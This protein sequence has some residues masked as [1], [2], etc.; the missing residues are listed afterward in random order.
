[1]AG[2]KYII[3]SLFTNSTWKIELGVDAKWKNVWEL[4]ENDGLLNGIAIFTNLAIKIN[5]T[6]LSGQN[7]TDP[8]KI[9]LNQFNIPLGRSFLRR[10]QTSNHNSYRWFYSP[11]GTMQGENFSLE[12][13]IYKGEQANC[14]LQLKPFAKNLN[15]AN[16]YEQFNVA[17]IASVASVRPQPNDIIA[18]ENQAYFHALEEDDDP[19]KHFQPWYVLTSTKIKINTS[20]PQS[21]PTYAFDALNFALR[22]TRGTL[23]AG[24]PFHGLVPSFHPVGDF[25]LFR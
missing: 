3:P 20:S 16:E 10:D 18:V 12:Y 25:I 13:G 1:M 8:P 21:D 9:F 4:W 11:V 2:Q 22:E 14:W 17:A 24:S 19:K 7:Q 6:L 23:F 5:E 15:K